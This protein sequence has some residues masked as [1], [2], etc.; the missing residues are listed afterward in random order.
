MT[1]MHEEIILTGLQHKERWGRAGGR[2]TRKRSCSLCGNH[3]SNKCR[4]VGKGEVF[5]LWIV[6]EGR[7]DQNSCRGDVRRRKNARVAPRFAASAAGGL[8]AGA[9]VSDR[10]QKSSRCERSQ[11]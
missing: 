1:Y 2:E 9:L 6:L 11:M 7:W 10:G 3:G 4:R 8:T 5:Q